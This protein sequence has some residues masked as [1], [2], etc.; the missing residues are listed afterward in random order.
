[1]I[2]LLILVPLLALPAAAAQDLKDPKEPQWAV[3]ALSVVRHGPPD[4]D[5]AF[6]DFNEGTSVTAL[7]RLPTR[8][9]LGLD[10]KGSKLEAFTDDKNTDLLKA[11]DGPHSSRLR[12]SASR[13]SPDGAFGKITFHA[14]GCPAAGATRVRV[15]GS[16]TVLVGNDEKELEKKD[17]SL[18]AGVELPIGTLKLTEPGRGT[19]TGTSLLTFVSYRGTRAIKTVVFLGADGTEIPCRRSANPTVRVRNAG[20]E[21]FSMTIRPT[22]RNVKLDRCTVRVTYFERVEEVVVPVNLEVGPGL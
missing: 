21:Q 12:V 13:L 10:L 5:P 15:K 18:K 11:E 3:H 9:L 4:E 2:R 17:V 14:P 19:T 22:D 8:F 20:G 16:V 7:L 6:R 1:M